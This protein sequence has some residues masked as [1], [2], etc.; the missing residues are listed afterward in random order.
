[1][2]KYD[3]IEE[4]KKSDHTDE[5]VEIDKF[6]PFHDS[7]GRF[8]SSHGMKTYSANPKTKAGAMAIQ[9]SAAAGHGRVMNVHRESK[10]E[11]IGQ[12]D[13]WLR[14]GVK[15]AHL[16]P[17]TSQQTARHT[18]NAKPTPTGR[19]SQNQ[20]TQPKQQPKQ[21]Q[22][23]QAQQPKQQTGDLA[24]NVANVQLSNA[25]KQALQA[26]D[27]WKKPVKTTQVANDNYQE[28]VDGKDLSKSFD[29]N[30][31]N[32][33]K[34]PIDAIA[35]AQGWNKGATVTNDREVFDKAA[36]Q[37]GRVMMRSVDGYGNLSGKDVA[38]QTMT[39]GDYALGGNGGKVYGSGR[40][41]VDTAISGSKLTDSR[42]SAGQ[43]E[44]YGYG[45]TQMMATVHPNAK[46]ATPTQA[47]KMQSDFYT[48]S[49]KD[50]ARFGRDVNTYI[51]SK[52]Y[53]GVKWHGDSDPGAYTTMFNNSAMI[54]YGGV[55]ESPW[56]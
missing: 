45:G 18:G 25:N 42:V 38:K 4:V 13:R 24:S 19:T 53:D 6:N 47:A 16:R 9:R 17:H 20:Q 36:K 39:N 54:Y 29:Y 12:N 14:T 3:E 26:R 51:A 49:S 55:A 35:E 23:Q 34:R 21:Q 33:N 46:I 30:K 28:R 48:L 37:A 1:M 8:S 31:M 22:N 32:T 5:I 40:Y 11:N 52:G 44:S 15:P 50:Q 10:G 27:S 41:M 7:I 43:M 2:S 56:D